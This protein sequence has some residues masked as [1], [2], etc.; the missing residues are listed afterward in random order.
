M[1][2]L[3]SDFLGAVLERQLAIWQLRDW[4]TTRIRWGIRLVYEWYTDGIRMVYGWYT[5]VF[6]RYTVVYGGVPWYTDG[7]QIGL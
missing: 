4:F 1:D 5:V 2:F 3:G 7:T 6:E